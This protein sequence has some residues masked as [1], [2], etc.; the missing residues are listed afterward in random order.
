MTGLW[1]KIVPV[2]PTDFLCLFLIAFLIDSY[3]LRETLSWKNYSSVFSI[4]E[5]KIE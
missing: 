2:S 1:V 3:I 5:K 4:S